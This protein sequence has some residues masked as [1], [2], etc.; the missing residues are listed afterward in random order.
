MRGRFE[1]LIVGRWG[2]RFR[3]RRF[4]CAIGRAGVTGD[5]REGDGATPAGAMRLVGLRYRADR[6]RRPLVSETLGF[7]ISA[8]GT[9]ELWSDDPDDPAYNHLVVSRDHSYSAERLR[10]A[11]RLYDI[12]AMTD[13]NWPIAKRGEGSAIFVHCWKTPRK[14]TAGC[15]A[16]ARADLVWIM[17]RWRRSSRLIV[18][19]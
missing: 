6:V 3:G 11:D 4:A 5:K 10:R 13:W 18:Q 16:F 8:I 2:A 14:P 15:V 19:P 12:V 17:R 7:G 9:A 1:D